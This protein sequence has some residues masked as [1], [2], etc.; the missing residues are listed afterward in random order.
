M[1]RFVPLYALA[2]LVALP[3]GVCACS[4]GTDPAPGTAAGS[5]VIFVGLDG[6]DWSLIDRH[7]V[8]GAMPHLAALVKGGRSGALATL[9]P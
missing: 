6:A 5:P 2:A 9:H 1:R 3:L 8:E 7:I 4:R